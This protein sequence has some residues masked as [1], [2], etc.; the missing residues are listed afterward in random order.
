MVLDLAPA[1]QVRVQARWQR[2]TV[3]EVRDALFG[4]AAP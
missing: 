2:H 1:L 3:Y 4:A